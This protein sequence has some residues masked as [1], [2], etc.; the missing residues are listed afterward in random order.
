M[1]I[2]QD[3]S[4]PLI[5]VVGSTGTQGGSVINNLA[6][7]YKPYRM[8]GL[9]RDTTKEAAVRLA[10]RSI[11]M[12]QCDLTADNVAGIEKAFEGAT[13]IFVGRILDA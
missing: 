5:V 3:P 9:T 6:S 7:S 12:V 2:S 4:Q 13:Y 11:E 8:R 10:E 1:T